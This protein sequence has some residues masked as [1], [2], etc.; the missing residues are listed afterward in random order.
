MSGLG[1]TF[2]FTHPEV[3]EVHIGLDES[4]LDF[5]FAYR[6]AVVHLGRP[7]SIAAWKLVKRTVKANV[8]AL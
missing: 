6:A 4:R 5:F 2:K 3:V 1:L 7:N 8:P